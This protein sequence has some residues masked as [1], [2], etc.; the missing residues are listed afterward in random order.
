MK[1]I[2]CFL[3]VVIC[4]NCKAQ[5]V[6]SILSQQSDSGGWYLLKDTANVKI[7]VK[8]TGCSGNSNFLVKVVNNNSSAVSMQWIFYKAGDDLSNPSLFKHF[9]AA[10]MSSNSGECPEPNNMTIPQSLVGFLYNGTTLNDLVF[11]IQFN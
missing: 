6:S 10:A 7:S 4:V 2:L 8:T 5:N 1:R 9:N 3:L 11:Q